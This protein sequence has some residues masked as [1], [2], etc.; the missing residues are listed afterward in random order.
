MTIIFL[1]KIFFSYPSSIWLPYK[2]SLPLLSSSSVIF[3]VECDE[4]RTHGLTDRTHTRITIYNYTI[5]CT[6][7]NC[8]IIY[9]T[10]IYLSHSL[11]VKTLIDL[12]LLSLSEADAGVPWEWKLL[13]LLNFILLV[14]RNN[15]FILIL[16]LNEWE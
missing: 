16:E 5:I 4:K 9:N 3:E 15:F 14:D 10:I 7:F 12:V 8:L 1:A 11:L 6:R 13:P 2:Q